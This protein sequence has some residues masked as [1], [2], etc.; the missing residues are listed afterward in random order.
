LLAAGLRLQ[1]GQGQLQLLEDASGMPLRRW[2]LQDRR[3]QRAEGVV[4]LL[5][6][7]QR[8][9]FIVVLAG[10]HELWEIS[11]DP[12]A[13]PVFAGLVHDYRM[14]EGLAEPGYLALRRTPLDAPLSAALL[15]DGQ[16]WL[17]AQQGTDAVL[18]HLD[19][20]RVI[21]RVPAVDALSARLQFTPD[22]ARVLVFG[23]GTQQRRL[24][25]RRWQL[26]TR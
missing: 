20:R 7:R 9:S 5:H 17:V 10:L 8:L 18:I 4:V 26:L 11:H 25:T 13:E 14:G 24:D 1:A 19:A 2:T 3:G 22:G 12:E 6:A 16:P 21:A 23:E 15:I